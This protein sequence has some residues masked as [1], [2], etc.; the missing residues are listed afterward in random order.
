MRQ[1]KHL[2]QPVKRRICGIGNGFPKQKKQ[3]GL[4]LYLLLYKINY[5]LTDL[6]IS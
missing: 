2:A 1:K 6:K 3:A 4:A 5:Q